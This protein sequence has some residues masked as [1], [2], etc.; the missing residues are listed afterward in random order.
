ML[1]DECLPLLR[2]MF[3][4]V[5]FPVIAYTND[6]RSFVLLVKAIR[7]FHLREPLM[8]EDK[9]LIQRLRR[10]S[11]DALEAVYDRYADY[12][13]TLAAGLLIEISRL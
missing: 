12:L 2:Q 4:A 3:N 13:L 10:G 1:N 8:V 9:L 11:T 7:S 6:L 5:D